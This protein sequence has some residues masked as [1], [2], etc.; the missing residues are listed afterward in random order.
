[1]RLL[2]CSATGDEGACVACGALDCGHCELLAGA[3]LG[4]VQSALTNLLLP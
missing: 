2:G 4:C 3:V 1:M